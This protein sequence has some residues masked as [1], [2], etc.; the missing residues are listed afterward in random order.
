MRRLA[1]DGVTESFV[2]IMDQ[3]AGKQVIVR[4]ILP[5]IVRDVSRLAS[6]EARVKDLRTIQHPI[7][8][9]VGELVS[10]DGEKYVIEDWRDSIDFQ[11]ILDW[12]LESRRT[13]PHNVYLNLA[14]QL[15]NALEALHARPGTESG[16]DSVLHMGLNPQAVHVDAHGKVFVGNYGMVVSPTQGAGSEA[17][18]HRTEYLAPEQT[19]PNE[20]L[21]PATDIFSLGSILFEMLTLK[22][23]FKAESNLQTIQNIRRAEVTT[24]LLE[25]KELLQGLDKV[26]Y[27][28]LSLNPRHRYQRAFVL[29]EDL[30]GLMAGFSFSHIDDDT[31]N[32]LKP[33]F[34]SRGAKPASNGP[35][36]SAH[37]MIP[38]ETT[39]SIINASIKDDKRSS[40]P[41]SF[42]PPPA[43]DKLDDTQ[44]HIRHAKGLPLQPAGPTISPDDSFELPEGLE[45]VDLEK[46]PVV[47]L[48]E[49]NWVEKKPP[50]KPSE[51]VTQWEQ[52]KKT[53]PVENKRQETPPP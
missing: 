14:T 6:V 17:Q 50:K 46:T 2:G 26:L 1:S 13:I 12:C 31:S 37:D 39:A 9:R 20:K 52:G 16:A 45:D 23:M 41:A 36:A 33:L 29:R 25:V 28:A 7:L 44:A 8:Q 21:T 40:F 4:R 43:E 48:D 30:R 3:P 51:E 11:R 15:C 18:A 10:V 53:P 35:L 19:S 24:H 5:H 27:R 42:G 22:P 34:R 47:P 32:F 38:A 49:T